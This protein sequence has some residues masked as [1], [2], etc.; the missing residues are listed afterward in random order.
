MLSS[1]F[2]RNI[3]FAVSVNRVICVHL[4]ISNIPLFKIVKWSHDLKKDEKQ[5]VSDKSN[6]VTIVSPPRLVFHINHQEDETKSCFIPVG[7]IFLV[8][9][10]EH[11][12]RPLVKAVCNFSQWNRREGE[13][14]RTPRRPFFLWLIEEMTLFPRWTNATPFLAMKNATVNCLF[15]RHH[16]KKL[17]PIGSRIEDTAENC[18]QPSASR[19]VFTF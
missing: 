12:S 2:S 8:D 19:L 3:S 6:L 14:G 13:H 7:R 15:T 11:A 9:A 4:Q 5:R 17:W 1:Y 18:L 10:S 16:V